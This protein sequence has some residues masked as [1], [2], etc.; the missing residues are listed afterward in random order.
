MTDLRD[1][2]AAVLQSTDRRLALED[3]MPAELYYQ[4]VAEAVIE[5]LGLRQERFEMLTRYATKWENQHAQHAPTQNCTPPS[6]PAK[7]KDTQ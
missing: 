3:E 2:I 5:A 1:K 4:A 7:P 6:E